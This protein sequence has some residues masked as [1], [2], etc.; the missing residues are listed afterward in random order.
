MSSIKNF[1][2]SKKSTYKQGYYYLKNPSKYKGD[3][4]KIIYRSGWERKFCI[5]CDTNPKI[6][7]WSSE[8]FKITYLS[9]VDNK[10]HRYFP[11]FYIKIKKKDEVKEYIVEIKPHKY[12]IKPKPPKRKT[13]KKIKN[14]K[15]TMK[16]FLVNESKWKAAER[17][18][19]ENGYEF[20]VITEKFLNKL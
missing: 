14:Y 5:Y 2:P 10:Q 4:N 15:H 16:R 1:K 6:V 3:S 19:K 9:Q 7:E 20:I 18:A 12:S 11:D 17:A 8:P 13:K